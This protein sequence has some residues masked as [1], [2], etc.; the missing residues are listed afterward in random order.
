M[1]KV[2]YDY[3]KDGGIEYWEGYPTMVSWFITIF[4][5]GPNVIG[6]VAFLVGSVF[7]FKAARGWRERGV[8]KNIGEGGPAYDAL[9]V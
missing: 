8:D 2:H 3:R 7:A 6:S 9:P 4:F 1:L 5:I